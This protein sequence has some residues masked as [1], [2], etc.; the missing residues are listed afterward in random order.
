[1]ISNSRTICQQ[2]L[3]IR[4]SFHKNFARRLT[5]LAKHKFRWKTINNLQQ[6]H[7]PKLVKNHMSNQIRPQW[8]RHLRK[9]YIPLRQVDHTKEEPRILPTQTTFSKSMS[10]HTTKLKAEMII[11]FHQINQS[12]TT[13]TDKWIS[14]KWLFVIS[15]DNLNMKAK[16]TEQNTRFTTTTWYKNLRLSGS[17]DASLWFETSRTSQVGRRKLSEPLRMQ[18]ENWELNKWKRLVRKWNDSIIVL[19]VAGE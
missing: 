4:H 11:A 13:I 19:P 12:I 15:K 6:N 18:V 3:C 17:R 9:R 8:I 10:A 14:N 1:M 5:L 16:Q 2:W 7:R